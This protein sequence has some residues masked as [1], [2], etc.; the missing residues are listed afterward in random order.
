MENMRHEDLGRLRQAGIVALIA[1]AAVSCA[2]NSG[3]AASGAASQGGAAASTAGGGQV[4]DMC[5]LLTADEVAAATGITVTST[6][7]GDFDASFYC[8][9]QLQPGTNVEGVAFDRLVAITKYAGAS[10]YDMA[11]PDGSPVP[12]IGDKAMTIDYTVNVLKG[13]VHFA[14]AVILHQPG[15]EDPTLLNKEEQ[16]SEELAKKAADRL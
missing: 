13:D 2:G 1:L 12:G 3:P 9:W 16:V 14:V 4:S 8:Q 15:D 10:S 7:H 11:A 6:G 5:S